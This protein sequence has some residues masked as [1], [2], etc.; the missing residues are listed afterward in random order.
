MPFKKFKSANNNPV[1]LKNII[2]ETKTNQV[3]TAAAEILKRHM[4]QELQQANLP[5]QVRTS[6][7]NSVEVQTG[8]NGEIHL[9]IKANEVTN[10]EYGTTSQ[11]EQPFILRALNAAR[12]EINQLITTMKYHR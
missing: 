4:T 12:T 10:I 2:D 3:L 7:I 1:N 9:Q 11:P 6:L 8:T 5:E